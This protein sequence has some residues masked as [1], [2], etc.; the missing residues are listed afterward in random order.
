M[1]LDLIFKNMLGC[2]PA[3]DAEIFFR[4]VVSMLLG[5]V[6]GIERE[7]TNKTAGLRTHIL[8]CLGSTVFTILSIY[9]F[10]CIGSSDGMRLVHDP[11][12]VAAQI[13]TGIGFIGGGAVLHYGI[14]IFGITTAATLWV[15]AS[16]GMAVGTGAY[17]VA[18][19]ATLFTF[20][21]LVAVRKFENK[22]LTRDTSRGARVK[23]SVSC[24][25]E[26]QDAVQEWFYKEFKNIQEISAHRASEAVNQVKLTFVV[27]I[28]G[29]DPVNMIYG[30]ISGIENI[31]SINVKQ[32][33]I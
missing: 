7:I 31:E 25:R 19:F 28:Q 13:V 17:S 18:I 3:F 15:T 26:N 5:L 21:V 10:A 22:F 30:K 14:N 6:I 29:K 23:I 24:A 4:L 11:S 32:V 16:I 20:I 2:L 33:L 1:D 27:D 12:R 8:V 9:S